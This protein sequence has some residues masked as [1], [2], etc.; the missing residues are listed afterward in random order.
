MGA[1]RAQARARQLAQGEQ[2]AKPAPRAAAVR[3]SRT[4]THAVRRNCLRL[5]TRH[6]A[7]RMKLQRLQP[8]AGTLFKRWTTGARTAD[9]HSQQSAGQWHAL[10]ARLLRWDMGLMPWLCAWPALP[11]E[12]PSDIVTRTGAAAAVATDGSGGTSRGAVCPAVQRPHTT[13][14]SSNQQCIQFL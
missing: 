11:P 9:G 8:D 5:H 10:K 13:V 1:C 14:E 6:Q 7:C 2:R 3:L 4:C 12:A